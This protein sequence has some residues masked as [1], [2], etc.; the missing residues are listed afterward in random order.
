MN[1]F[2]MNNV[3]SFVGVLK[4]RVHPNI[5]WRLKMKKKAQSKAIAQEQG[6]TQKIV[7]IS[8]WLGYFTV[9]GWLL[10]KVLSN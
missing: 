2:G 8:F 9:W 10:S 4:E 7:Q 1:I 5:F 6:T 3:F